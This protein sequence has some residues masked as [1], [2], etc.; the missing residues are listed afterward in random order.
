MKPIEELKLKVTTNSHI[1]LGQ[2]ARPG[3]CHTNLC[4]TVFHGDTNRGVG[5]IHLSAGWWQWVARGITVTPQ[6]KGL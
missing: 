1:E 4:I 2:V 3:S 6:S 5:E